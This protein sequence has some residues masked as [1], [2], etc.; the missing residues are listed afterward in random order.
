MRRG[1]RGQHGAVARRE[2]VH[3]AVCRVG[4]QFVPAVKHGERRQGIH[5]Q[6]GTPRG[7]RQRKLRRADTA[8]GTEHRI[9]RAK[10]ETR[11]ADMT[12][13]RLALAI[14][15]EPIAIARGVLLQQDQAFASR[16]Q[17]AGGNADGFAGRQLPR[18]GMARG[19]FSND[20][21]R[22]GEVLGPHGIA[23]HRRKVGR[24]LGA[25]GQQR[26]GKIAADGS[27][28]RDG[29]GAERL[30]LGQQARLRLGERQ[31]RGQ[32]HSGARQAPL[33][34]PV[35]SSRRTPSITMPLSSALA[36]S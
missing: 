3:R 5:G 6:L 21:P 7:E 10:I 33:L 14:E 28:S 8:A 11:A 12:S 27:F 24:G 16:H 9:A 31:R 13:T 23:V 2:L 17:G 1:Q 15:G 4:R 19:A 32:A 26:L 30:D 18:E 22:P 29:L 35:F 20:L 25:R 34:P 36:I